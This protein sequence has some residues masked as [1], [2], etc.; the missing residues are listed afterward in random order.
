MADFAKTWVNDYGN[1]LF[2]YAFKKVND[3][4]KAEDLVQDT[5]VS[6]LKGYD[7]FEKRSSEKSWLFS[8]LKHKIIDYYRSKGRN[9]TDNFESDEMI[10]ALFDEV[11]HWKNRVNEWES[12]E[13]ALQN[14]EFRKV[15]EQCIGNLPET[16]QRV[17]EYRDLDGLSGE[18][19]CKILDLSASNLWVVTHRARHK[20]RDCLTINWFGG[21]Q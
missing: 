17:F 16:Q 9:K 11:G 21:A 3:R 13:L 10:D 1:L 5:F 6:A 15:L 19:I 2:G 14:S 7:K 4:E 8:I 20:L 18:D 12:P